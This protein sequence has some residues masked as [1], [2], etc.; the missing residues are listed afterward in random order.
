M[1]AVKQEGQKFLRVLLLVPRK[2][3]REPSDCLLEISGHYEG[4]PAGPHALDQLA[5][6]SSNFALHAERVFIIDVFD[7]VIVGEV[8]HDG[9]SV[10]QTLKYRTWT[11]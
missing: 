8:L 11:F 3:W 2:L 4:I 1:K 7:I 6:G 10:G 5:E 9:R